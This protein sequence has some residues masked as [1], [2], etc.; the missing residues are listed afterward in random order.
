MN[1]LLT[2]AYVWGH[3]T[4]PPPCHWEAQWLTCLCLATLDTLHVMLCMGLLRTQN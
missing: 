4:P 2:L 1:E 3:S